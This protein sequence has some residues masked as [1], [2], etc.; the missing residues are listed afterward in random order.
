MEAT[1][2]TPTRQY[3]ISSKSSLICPG[4]LW[5]QSRSHATA[6][7]CL[8]RNIELKKGQTLLI[9]GA[10]SSL[11]Q[12]AL[13]LAVRAGARV[14]TTTRNEM[15][16]AKLKEMGAIQVEVERPDLSEH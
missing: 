12:A 9:R 2:S 16:F 1:P 6:W 8:F 14:I 11:G 15:R 5:Q 7:T 4:R 13:N 3:Q 10:T